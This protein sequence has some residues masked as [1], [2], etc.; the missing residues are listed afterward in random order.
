MGQAVTLDTFS[1][2]FELFVPDR[3]KLYRDQ[4]EINTARFS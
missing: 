1:G 2:G 3:L 4:H